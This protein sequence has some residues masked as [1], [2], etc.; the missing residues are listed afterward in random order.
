MLGMVNVVGVAA[1]N[2]HISNIHSFFVD[3][4][5]FNPDSRV[6]FIGRLAGDLTGDELVNRDKK[7]AKGIAKLFFENFNFC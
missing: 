6:A 3:E 2:G 5:I 4:F 1:G 7:V